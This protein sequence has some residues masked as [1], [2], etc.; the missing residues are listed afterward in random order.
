MTRGGMELE[1]RSPPKPELPP[2]PALPVPEKPASP[3][4]PVPPRELQEVQSLSTRPARSETSPSP[5]AR[6]GQGHGRPRERRRVDTPASSPLLAH[7]APNPEPIG[8]GSLQHALQR[9]PHAP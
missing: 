5:E 8:A 1:A 2:E 6:A 7:V 3:G 9:L 4:V